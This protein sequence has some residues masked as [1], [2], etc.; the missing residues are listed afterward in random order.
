MKFTGLSALAIVP[1]VAN[2]QLEFWL[3]IVDPTS[4]TNCLNQKVVPC[5]TVGLIKRGAK[6]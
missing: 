6:S 2:L 4:S 5:A 3:K 1:L